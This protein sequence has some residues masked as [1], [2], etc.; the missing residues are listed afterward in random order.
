MRRVRTQLNE[1]AEN[2]GKFLSEIRSIDN[3]NLV[4]LI[5]GI[6]HCFNSSAYNRI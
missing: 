3:R 2:A 6:R 4:K 5:A 1:L